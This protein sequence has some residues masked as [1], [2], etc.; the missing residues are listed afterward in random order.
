MLGALALG[1]LAAVAALRPAAADDSR[2]ATPPPAAASPPHAPVTLPPAADAATPLVLARFSTSYAHDAEHRARAFNVELGAEA[3]DGKTL[4]PGA[5]FSFNDAVG[6]RTAAFGFARSVVLRDGMLAEGVGGGAC[7]VASTLHAAA[8][9]GGLEVVS[10]A[11]HSRP[12]AYIRMGLDATVALAAGSP[13]IDLKLGNPTRAPVVVHA[14]A[15]RGVLEIWLETRGTT[16]PDVSVTSEIV[17]RTAFPRVVERDKRIKDDSV[18]VRAFG[19]PGYRVRRT[20]EIRAADGTVRR[21]IRID[22]YPPTSEI[23]RVAPSFD[24]SRLRLR[25]GAEPSPGEDGAEPASGAEDAAPKTAPS[26]VDAGASRP[27][28]VQLRPSTRVVLDNAGR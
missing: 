18:R 28:L 7:Q 25:A 10:R 15:A 14:R 9:L 13:A 24:E 22:V 19:I 1:A 6:E 2:P 27:A 4:A 26:V 21:D 8:L 5:T 16:R 11:P 20:R 12:S 3:I 23:V 17:D